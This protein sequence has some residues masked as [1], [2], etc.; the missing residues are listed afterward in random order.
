MASPGGDGCQPPTRTNARDRWGRVHIRRTPRSRHLGRL[1]PPLRPVSCSLFV[2]VGWRR[3]PG[4]R[5]DGFTGGGFVD[6]QWSSGHGRKQKGAWAITGLGH[7]LI[8]WCCGWR[9][10]LQSFGLKKRTSDV[11]F[12][13]ESGHKWLGRGMSACDPKRT[14]HELKSTSVE[15]RVRCT[16]NQ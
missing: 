2:P 8:S 11:G 6:Y 14:S 4:G 5:G 12:T 10:P 3:C 15:N 1:M 7:G 9:C 13:S 16:E